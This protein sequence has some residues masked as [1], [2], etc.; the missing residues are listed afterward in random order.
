MARETEKAD[1]YPGVI[2]GWSPEWPTQPGQ[3]W[4]YGKRYP[5]PNREN[6]LFYVQVF[7]SGNKRMIYEAHGAFIYH[8]E[9]SGV[10][11]KVVLPVI[12]GSPAIVL[13]DLQKELAD[14]GKRAAKVFN[15]TR[16]S[17]VFFLL[18]R[19]FPEVEDEWEWGDYQ[20]LLNRLLEKKE[21]AN[22]G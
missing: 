2:T 19:C 12:P 4:F 14:F 5:N 7:E 21:E 10:W 16:S 22:D 9:A 17:T 6:E 15:E 20:K 11:Q 8:S 18:Q 13:G 1:F 3:Y